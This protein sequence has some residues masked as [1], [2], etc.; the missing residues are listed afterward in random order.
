MRLGDGR[1][2]ASGSEKFTFSESDED[3]AVIRFR[4]W[5]ANKNGTDLI[6]IPIAI[7]SST[8]HATN[9]DV[10]AVFH[11]RPETFFNA[12][13]TAVTTRAAFPD[14]IWSWVRR[15]ILTRPQY[16]AHMT[17]IEQIGYLS[18]IQKPATSPSLEEVGNLYLDKP[19]ISDNWRAKCELF[20]QEFCK[21]VEV[22][23]LRDLTQEHLIKYADMVQAAAETPTY[24]RQR[25][26]AIK[27]IINHPPKRG[28]WAVDAKRALAFCAVLVPPKKSA[29]DP[30]PISRDA[31]QALLK[32]ADDSMKAILLLALNACMYG[33]EV[34]V[35]EWSDVDLD[36][37]TLCTERSKTG[38]V[39]IA[40]LWPRTV[41]ALRKLPKVISP[42]FVTSGTKMQHNYQTVYKTF[43]AVRKA[44]NL[45]AVQFGHIRDG[46]YT[47]AVEAGIVLDVCRLLAGYATGI[48]DHY[49]K[50]RPQMVA[51]ACAAI[52][53][54][55]FG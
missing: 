29:V 5:K 28:K 39:R 27:S 51:A 41:D 3:L 40:T 52:E 35:V 23:K 25:F 33:G 4:Q 15:E 47:A 32:A 37:R 31:F 10:N 48:S 22:R 24:T 43:K 1:W 42:I 55:Y 49:V 16:V 30:T 21:T 26:G 54:A 20:W 50:R 9:A 18:E 6:H 7:E 53:A 2:R 11:P 13:G 45:P 44:A 46:A 19:S 34:A 38:I 36:K 8:M 17:G 12:D 14:A